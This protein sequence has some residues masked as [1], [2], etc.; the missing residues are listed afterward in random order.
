MCWCAVKK[1]LTHSP[2][3]RLHCINMACAAS[4]SWFAAEETQ[5]A[6]RGGTHAST[7][8]WY[9]MSGVV[10]DMSATVVPEPVPDTE[11]GMSTPAIIMP[12][13]RSEVDRPMSAVV[14][15][16]HNLGTVFAGY[17]VWKHIPCNIKY[18]SWWFLIVTL[19]IVIFACVLVKTTLKSVDFWQSYREEYVGSFSMAHGVLSDLKIIETE[20]TC[21]NY[22]FRIIRQ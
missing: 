2:K 3:E 15:P 1:L 4:T 19:T 11:G 7:S 22:I 16:Q 21:V 18:V 6:G 14:R 10:V 12:R 9:V 17:L 13:Q 5:G 8:R 20:R